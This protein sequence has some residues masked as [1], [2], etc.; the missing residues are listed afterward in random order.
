MNI[1]TEDGW[2]KRGK[3]GENNG[4]MDWRNARGTDGRRDVRVEEA[5]VDLR[6][7]RNYIT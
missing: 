1:W 3:G 5:N 6:R 7:C 4:R 2:R